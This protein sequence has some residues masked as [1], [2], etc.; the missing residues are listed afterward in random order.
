MKR[1][2][3]LTAV[4][5]L[6]IGAGISYAQTQTPSIV[7]EWKLEV[8]NFGYSE[9][10]ETRLNLA[11]YADGRSVITYYH[12]RNWDYRN[13]WRSNQPA[14][15]WRRTGEIISFSLPGDERRLL[16]EGRFFTDNL[17]LGT[18]TVPFD[19]RYSFR[20]MKMSL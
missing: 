4:F 8:D 20:L 18:V 1:K 13:Y 2:I 3:F 14:G 16:F 11:F 10:I 19:E 7:G 12:N 9:L 5:L 15:P 6:I 17:I